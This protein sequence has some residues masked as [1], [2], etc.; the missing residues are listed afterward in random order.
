MLIR[1]L[2][3]AA[4]V[5]GLFGLAAPVGGALAD[6]TPTGSVQASAALPLLTFV[7]P[8]VG[9]IR[10]YIGPTIIEGKTIS[11]G[12]NVLMPGVAPSPMTWTPP[13]WTPPR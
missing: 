9:P 1:K 7:P 11:P 13:S 2:S 5:L 10:V 12:V 4:T 6:T 8:K 3:T